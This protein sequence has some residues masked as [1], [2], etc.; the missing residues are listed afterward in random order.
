MSSEMRTIPRYNYLDI[1]PYSTLSVSQ[2]LRT[3][4]GVMIA[5]MEAKG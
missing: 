4:A 3:R 2:R 5:L 1:V